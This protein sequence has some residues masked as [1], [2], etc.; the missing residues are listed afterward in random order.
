MFP[1]V[2]VSLS[3]AL[4]L[5]ELRKLLPDLD[6]ATIQAGLDRLIYEVRVKKTGEGTKTSPFKY[7]RV[8]GGGG[9]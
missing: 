9:G 6:E 8:A 2:D 1:K 3:K 5:A 4:S 7:Y